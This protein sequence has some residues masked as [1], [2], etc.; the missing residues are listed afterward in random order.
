MHTCHAHQLRHHPSTSGEIEPALRLM[1]MACAF[2]RLAA[3][4]RASP[5]TVVRNKPRGQH[6]P[7]CDY[8]AS[9]S[10]SRAHYPSTRA[11]CYSLANVRV[12][13]R[14]CAANWSVSVCSS[15]SCTLHTNCWNHA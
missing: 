14:F 2:R 10:F 8:V 12:L 13:L 6:K 7:K 9:F 1:L 3:K 4:A 15:H 5:S 11:P